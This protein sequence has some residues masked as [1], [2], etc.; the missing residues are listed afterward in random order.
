ME[1]RFWLPAGGGLAVSGCEAGAGCPAQ[2]AIILQS[3]LQSGFAVGAC[4]ACAQLIVCAQINATQ[5]IMD[6]TAFTI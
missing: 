6:N 1:S 5:N 2:Q 4:G 3:Q